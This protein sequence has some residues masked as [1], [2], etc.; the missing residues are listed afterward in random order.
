MYV[1]VIRGFTVAFLSFSAVH[2]NVHANHL[3]NT[4]SIFSYFSCV[5]IRHIQFIIIFS[6]TFRFVISDRF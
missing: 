1:V 2:V 3:C 4:S 6:T 5:T